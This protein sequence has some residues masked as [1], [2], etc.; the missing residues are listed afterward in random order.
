MYVWSF[1]PQ[2]AWIETLSANNGRERKK[3]NKREKWVVYQNGIWLAD[4]PHVDLVIFSTRD[5]HSGRL[6]AN[7]ETIDIRCMCHKLLCETTELVKEKS[8]PPS[9]RSICL[10][11]TT[12]QKTSNR[13]LQQYHKTLKHTKTDH[14]KEYMRETIARACAHTQCTQQERNL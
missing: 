14:N 10:L 1:Q 12:S 9:S 11:F 3:K 4:G 8:S 5:K 7:F 13:T 2:K 6:L